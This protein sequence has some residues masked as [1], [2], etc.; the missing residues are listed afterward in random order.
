[1]RESGQKR[2]SLGRKFQAENPGEFMGR[3]AGPGLEEV[4]EERIVVVRDLPQR[5]ES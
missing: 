5:L 1:V 2:G 4:V 3:Y